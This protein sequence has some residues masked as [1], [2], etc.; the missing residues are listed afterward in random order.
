MSK[1]TLD[2]SLIDFLDKHKFTKKE[3]KDPECIADSVSNYPDYFGEV[4]ISDD[5]ALELAKK[6]CQLK[7]LRAK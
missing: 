1:Q 6:Y 5:E 3:L 2:K 4:E 7:T